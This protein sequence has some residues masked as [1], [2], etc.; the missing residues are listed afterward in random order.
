MLKIALFALVALSLVVL[1]YVVLNFLLKTVFRKALSI[2][3]EVTVLVSSFS[4]L[5]GILSAVLIYQDMELKNR[6]Y[7]YAEPEVIE[8]NGN[9]YLSEVAIRNCGNTPAYNVVFSRRLFVNGAEV[10][11]PAGGRGGSLSIFPNGATYEYFPVKYIEGDEIAYA[12]DIRYESYNGRKYAY[13]SR[14]KFLR[15]GQ[16]TFAW[17]SIS[18]R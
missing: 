14:Y 10:K 12:V 5:A 16:D 4:A 11:N 7:V 17:K 15:M 6:P 9:I 1:S 18:S 13:A 3:V 8:S 2:P